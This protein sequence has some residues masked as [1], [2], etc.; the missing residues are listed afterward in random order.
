VLTR[1]PAFV[2]ALGPAGRWID[3]PAPATPPQQLALEI[4]AAL[5]ERGDEFARR[6]R[7]AV[8]AAYSWRRHAELAAHIW[9]ELVAQR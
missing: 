3:A 7:Q 2:E 8:A 4:A 5:A 1:A 9:R 6:S